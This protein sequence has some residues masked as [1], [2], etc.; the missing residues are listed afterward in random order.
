[1][2]Q[3]LDKLRD[4]YGEQPEIFEPFSTH[5]PLSDRIDKVDEVIDDVPGAN[6]D[7]DERM[8]IEEYEVI[9]KLLD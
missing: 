3:F 2:R 7:S 9:K 4:R 1:M 8:Y 6:M 5:P